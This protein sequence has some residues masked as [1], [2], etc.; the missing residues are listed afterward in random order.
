MSDF[1]PREQSEDT[2][3]VNSSGI[4]DIQIVE[5]TSDTN[6]EQT[7]IL[8]H[9]LRAMKN[10]QMELDMVKSPLQEI[11]EQDNIPIAMTCEDISYIKMQREENNSN[12]YPSALVQ[13]FAELQINED[14]SGSNNIMQPQS[15]PEITIATLNSSKRLTQKYNQDTPRH[16]VQ[17][18][19]EPERNFSL[20]EMLGEATGKFKILDRGHVRQSLLTDF[21]KEMSVA[22]ELE[23]GESERQRH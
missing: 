2:Y 8:N 23:S 21:S 7:R 17:D 11:G 6:L 1:R 22:S 4:Q 5:V 20:Y 13:S 10:K 15:L 16:G 19:N 12:R 14:K 18:E 9:E 3:P